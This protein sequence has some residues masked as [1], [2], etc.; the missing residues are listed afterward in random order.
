MDGNDQAGDCSVAAVFHQE[1]VLSANRPSPSEVVGTA[2]EALSQYPIICGRGDQGCYIPDVLDYWRDKGIT[3]GGK[4]TR[5]SG[6]VLVDAKNLL[7]QKIAAY[8][9]GGL[10][11][12]I[13]L[14]QSWYESAAPGVVWGDDTSPIIGGHSIA[15]PDFDGTSWSVSTWALLCA[16]DPAALMSPRIDPEIYAVLGL[17]WADNSGLSR[18]TVSVLRNCNPI[19]R[20]SRPAALPTSLRHPSRRPLC[21][22]LLP[23]RPT[24]WSTLASLA[25]WRQCS[26]TSKSRGLSGA[27]VADQWTQS[28]GSRHWLTL[29]G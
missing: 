8:L 24:E 1:G 12:G 27:T 18:R 16:V 17:D 11:A 19:W 13:N 5:I 26:S 2:K 10:H 9:F 22:A 21:L 7:L 15:L 3:M 14:P 23:V 25:R 4:V 6:Y 28:T 20:S 29:G